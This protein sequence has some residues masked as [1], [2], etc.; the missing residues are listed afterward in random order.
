MPCYHPIEA[1][2]SKEVNPSG[3]RSLVF[4]YSPSKCL[5]EKVTI[6]CGQCIGCR[7]E[8]SRQWAIR[9]VHEAQMW[10]RNC[11]ITLTYDAA[12]L[13][14]NGTL[15]HR[16]F[17]LF[18]KRL[19]KK[20]GAGIRYF[21]CGEYGEKGGRPHYHACLFNFDFSDRKLWRKS[22]DG[23]NLYI[24]ESLNELWKD[25]TG[26]SI[27]FTTVGDVT[28][29]SAAYVARYITKKKFGAEAETHYEFADGSGE[30]VGSRNREYCAMSRRPGIGRP[31]IEKYF[32]ST[33]ATDSVV[34]R[35]KEMRV[36]KAYDR[37]YEKFFGCEFDQIQFIRVKESKKYAED[38]SFQRLMTK[39]F[40]HAVKLKQLRR[41]YENGESI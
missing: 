30:I 19:R 5:D 23:S 41:S 34:M 21:M 36:P 33:Y 16:D 20:Y 17:Q 24:S 10:E 35:G 29:E 40:C 1:W 7:L 13:P 37:W 31:W 39:E 9:C 28:F 32:K 25:G 26:N 38:N 14:A 15:F 2:R 8:R 6:A 12:H 22:F 3:K 11:F 27:G 4:G 18:I